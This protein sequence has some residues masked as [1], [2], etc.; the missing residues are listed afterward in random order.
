MALLRFLPWLRSRLA[1][2]DDARGHVGEA[3]RGLDLVDVLPALAAGAVG[4]ELDVRFVQLDAAVVL[5]HG[6]D[7]HAGEAGVPLLGRVERRDA[8]QSVD[9]AFAVEL[10]VGVVAGD[11]ERGVAHAGF[12]TG[13]EV[14]HLGLVAAAARTSA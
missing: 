10:A 14:F 12:V 1:V 11:L 5:D 2:H 13:R 8:H 6:R 9:A 4:V 7:I 3:H